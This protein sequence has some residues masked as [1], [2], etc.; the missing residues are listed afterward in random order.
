MQLP[1]RLFA[2]ANIGGQ[3]EFPSLH[4]PFP[5]KPLLSAA[6]VSVRDKPYFPGGFTYRLLSGIS[7]SSY[8]GVVDIVIGT[9]FDAAYSNK[10]RCPVKSG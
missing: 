3:G 4:T 1:L 7:G 6:S 2:F 5:V 10:Q 9:V 8:E